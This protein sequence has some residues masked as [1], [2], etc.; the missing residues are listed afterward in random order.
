MGI[1]KQKKKQQKIIKNRLSYWYNTINDS[2]STKSKKVLTGMT[3]QVKQ[4]KGQLH[5]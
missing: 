2:V 5:Q 1:K 4:I 3:A